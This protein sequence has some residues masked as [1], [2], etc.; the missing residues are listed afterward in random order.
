MKLKETEIPIETE[1]GMI[2]GR[3]TYLDE[4]SFINEVTVTLRGEILNH[5]GDHL[6]E[7]TFNGINFFSTIELDFDDHCFNSS[8][9]EISNSKKIRGFKEIDHSKKINEN[10]RHYYFRTYD[11]VFEVI[12]E[13]FE[14]KLKS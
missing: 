14:F 10:H 4:I 11:S 5:N 3:S 9:C 8:F 13:S 6:Y 1:I 12:A 2:K 7:I